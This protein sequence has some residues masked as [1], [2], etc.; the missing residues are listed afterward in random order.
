M[1][2]SQISS[3]ALVSFLG[4]LIVS[5]ILWRIF[6][7][8]TFTWPFGFSYLIFGV[9]Y[10]VI[11]WETYKMAQGKIALLIPIGLAFPASLLA[12][13]FKPA[14]I[15]IQ[16]TILSI[17]GFSQYYFLGSVLDD[18]IKKYYANKSLHVDRESAGGPS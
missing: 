15:V 16:L 14:G 10:H 18:I 7:N 12:L 6:G 17:L 5:S 2:F 13:F 1:T 11:F 3:Y 9:T 8:K 4:L